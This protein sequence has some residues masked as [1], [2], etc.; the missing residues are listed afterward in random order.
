MSEKIREVFEPVPFK[1]LYVDF[2]KNE[3][4]YGFPG[5]RLAEEDGYMMMR[6]IEENLQNK[7]SLRR[8]GGL[9]I[10]LKSVG[11]NEDKV[12]PQLGGTIHGVNFLTY[13]KKVGQPTKRTLNFIARAD[14]R[15][16]L[17]EVM[18]AYTGFYDSLG[19]KKKRA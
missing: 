11:D 8:N 17:Y 1:V 7:R 15:G 13:A 16:A 12:R 2:E 4:A 9:K 14:E 18:C 19:K 6:R 3:T 10:N 5:K